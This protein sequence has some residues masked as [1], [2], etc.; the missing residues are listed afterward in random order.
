MSIEAL[1]TCLKDLDKKVLQQNEV[2][3]KI[4]GNMIDQVCTKGCM[5]GYLPKAGMSLIKNSY[6]DNSS[7]D[8]VVIYNGETLTTIIYTNE[9]QTNEVENI[10]SFGLSKS[11]I[12]IFTKV[13][14]GKKNAQIIQELFISKSTLKTHLNNIYKKLPINFQKYKTRH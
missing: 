9:S 10:K 2:C 8:A 5:I 1:G 4:C 7:V 3:L 11:E 14:E 6:V 13:I 12:I